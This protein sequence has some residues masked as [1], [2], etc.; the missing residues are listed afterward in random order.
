VATC[1]TAAYWDTS[2]AATTSGASRTVEPGDDHA[3]GLVAP[4]HWS[5]V[6]IVQRGHYRQQRCPR[7]L[8]HAEGLAARCWC[9]EF[10]RGLVHC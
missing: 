7:H 2:V 4:L 8:V 3:A 9:H 5:N 6:D 1:Q 10:S